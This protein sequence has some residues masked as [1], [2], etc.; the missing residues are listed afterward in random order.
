ARS[1]AP[2]RCLSAWF[3]RASWTVGGNVGGKVCGPGRL[4]LGWYRSRGCWS[5]L[6]LDPRV[7]L[8]GLLGLHGLGWRLIG[9]EVIEEFV[10]LGLLGRRRRRVSRSWCDS[11]DQS[12]AFEPLRV[13]GREL[14]RTGA[15][16]LL[17]VD[18]SSLDEVD[19]DRASVVGA[20][21]STS[22]PYRVKVP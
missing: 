3:A 12:Y 7:D 20:P 13:K 19:G 2:Q 8:I 15:V 21:V 6:L 14:L 4:G 16:V 1:R 18:P 17:V 22:S 10:G 11:I 9:R 5:G